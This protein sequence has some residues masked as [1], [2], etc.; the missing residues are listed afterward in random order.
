MPATPAR[1][2]F[3]IQ[4]YRVSRSGPD[5]D[6]VLK[7]GDRARDVDEPIETFF[8]SEADVQA[9]CDQRLTLL[10]ADRRRF[11]QTVV[12]EATALGMDVSQTTPTI[13]VIDEERLADFP[14]AVVEL[15][16][17]FEKGQSILTTWG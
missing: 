16:V 2:G 1:I 15:G 3:I 7:Y 14:A 10:K 5:A 11:Q 17:D 12:G 4:E 9:L 13:Q 6:V 8:D